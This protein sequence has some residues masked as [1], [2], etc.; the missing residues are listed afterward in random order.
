[1]KQTTERKINFAVADEIEIPSTFLVS[2]DA[3]GI[4]PPH[5][6]NSMLR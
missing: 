2:S 4:S 3:N 1:M 6:L 5:L